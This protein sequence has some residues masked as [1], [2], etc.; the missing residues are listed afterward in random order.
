MRRVTD[1]LGLSFCLALLGGCN[2]NAIT[3]GFHK[4]LPQQNARVLVWGGHPSALRMTE[5]W[6][7]RH[8]LTTVDQVRIQQIV[9][10]Q[11]ITVKDAWQDQKELLQIGKVARADFVVVVHTPFT[12]GAP[13]APY[14]GPYGGGTMERLE[15]IASVSIKGVSVE[16]GETAWSGSARYPGRYSDLENG[17]EELTCQALATAWGI[18]PIG[19]YPIRA[20]T[21]CDIADLQSR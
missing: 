21:M 13:G 15:Y 6:L 1:L 19:H 10:H 20:Q 18:R 16:T 14:I 12:K 17:L 3:E 8:G 9:N 2:M 11:H 4:T 7:Q 5:L